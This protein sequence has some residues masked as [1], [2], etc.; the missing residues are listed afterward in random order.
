MQTKSPCPLLFSAG[1][2]QWTA[3]TGKPYTRAYSYVI[4]QDVKELI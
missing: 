3:Y 1:Q 2:G 4:L